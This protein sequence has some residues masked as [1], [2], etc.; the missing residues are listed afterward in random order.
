[1]PSALL[2]STR[3]VW[4]LPVG[5]GICVARCWACLTRCVMAISP[6][7]SSHL[8]VGI[9]IIPPTPS[10]LSTRRHWVR[11]SHLH[12]FRHGGVGILIPSRLLTRRCWDRPCRRM[13]GGAAGLEHPR[14]RGGIGLLGSWGFPGRPQSLWDRLLVVGDLPCQRRVST[15]V[16]GL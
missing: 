9:G 6:S 1:M 13:R 8:R 11:S 14:R 10:C 7:T 5:V 15:A 4:A 3:W 2:G 12:V 16:V